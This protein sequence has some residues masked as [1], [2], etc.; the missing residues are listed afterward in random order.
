MLR[1]LHRFQQATDH[2]ILDA[3]LSLNEVQYALA[4]DYG[5]SSWAD[6]KHH[7]ESLA[8]RSLPEEAGPPP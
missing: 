8:G 4:M 5:F 1:S 7:V 3:D 6:M 2:E